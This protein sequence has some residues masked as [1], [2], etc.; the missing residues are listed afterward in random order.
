M[1]SN[2][3]ELLKLREDYREYLFF[4]LLED[5]IPWSFREWFDITYHYEMLDL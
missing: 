1:T 5:S 2:L 3:L 4:A